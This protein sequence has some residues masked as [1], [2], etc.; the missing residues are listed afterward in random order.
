MRSNNANR[1]QRCLKPISCPVPS[2]RDVETFSSRDALLA[3]IERSHGLD[4]YILDILMP[5]LNG[6][7]AEHRLR[8]LGD[9]GEIIYLT[10]SNDFAAGSYDVHA[11]FY[12][13]KPVEKQKMFK[14]LDGAVEKL[15]G[16]R[17][18]A[19]MVNAADDPRRIL[20]E[21]IRYVERVG[22]ACAFIVPTGMW[23]FKPFASPFAR[24]RLPCWRISAFPYV[25]PALC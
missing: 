1:W 18:G 3:C 5:A 23:I 13:L 21:G 11:F 15:R 19:I 9:A 22:A 12:L 17:A 6:I 16:W 20:L 8:A 14:I 7:E 2:S 24:Q 25:E 4:L 10:T